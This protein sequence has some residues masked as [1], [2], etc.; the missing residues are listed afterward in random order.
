M[1]SIARLSQ[2]TVGVIPV[3]LS[4]C[5]IAGPV[6]ADTSATITPRLSPD[7]LGAK[8]A[9]S[10]RVKFTEPSEGVPAAVRRMS[11]SFPAGLVL[12]LP[13][14]RSC[15]ASRLRARGPMGCP[16]AS[17]LGRGQAVVEAHLGSQTM[18]ESISLWIFL[19]PLR[20]LQP[21]VMILGRGYTPFDER[22]VFSGS[23]VADR[24]PYGERLVMSIPPIATLPLEPDASI[25]TFSLTVGATK[26]SREHDRNTVLVPAACPV[27]GFPVAGELAYADGSNGST[28][29]TIPCP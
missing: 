7:R 20:N 8:G 23:L 15:S 2:G 4:A 28:S 5:L 25:V 21:T 26:S 1:R 3:M 9:V 22:V 19:G 24:A 13:Q 17:A 18:A 27:G 29:A 14:L 16:A 6:H 11:L 12:E 10:L